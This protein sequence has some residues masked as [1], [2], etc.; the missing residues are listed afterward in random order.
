[1]AERFGARALLAQDGVAGER[2]LAFVPWSAATGEEE[3]GVLERLAGALS[4]DL[5]EALAAASGEGALLPRVAVGYS[6]LFADASMRFERLVER[7]AAEAGAMLLNEREKARLRNRME[8]RELLAER[9]LQVAW[10]P[11]IDLSAA[12]ILGVEALCRG[13]VGS[14]F[15]TAEHLFS[16]GQVEDLAH[17]L[18]GAC[19]ERIFSTV[20]KLPADRLLFANILPESILDARFD[21]AGFAASVR[22]AGLEP[23]RVVLEIAE[24][25]RI[26]G[27][28]GFRRRLQPLR[29]DGFQIAVDDVGTGY[30]SLRLLPEVEP[31]FLK[32]DASLVRDIDRHPTKQGVLSTILDMGGRLGAEVICEGVENARELETCVRLGAHHGQGY[33]LLPPAPDMRDSFGGPPALA[34]RLP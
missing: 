30:A 3:L 19:C 18:D 34:R 2:L 28:A 31:D 29:E 16:T 20:P 26:P 15:E 9:R 8:L 1:V 11:I 13:P 10:Q 17:E 4:K 27:Y 32:V 22:A 21:A 5:Q 23:S 33:H 6:L 7:A 25:G 12:E 14:N 24:R